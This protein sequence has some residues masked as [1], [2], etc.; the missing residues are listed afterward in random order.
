[1]ATSN[2]RLCG[3]CEAQHITKY[4]DQWCPECDE[5]LCSDCESHHKISKSSRNHGVISIENYQKLPSSISEIGN[6]C[7][8]HDMKYTHF[9]QHHDTPC[10]PDCISTHHKDCVGL[11]SIREIIK[12]SK[13]S[14]LIDNIQQNLTDIKNNLD[15]IMKNRQQNMSEIQQQRQMF[16]DQI[17]QMRVKINSHLDTIEQNILQELDD[18][19]D[20]IKSKINELLKQI[21]QNAKTV[22]GLQSNIIAVK[23]YASD[24]QTFLGSKVIE[25]EVKKEEEYLMALP[26]DGCLQQLN[27][28]Y[29]INT[30]IQEILSTITTFGS[31]SIETSPPSVVIKTMKAKQAQIMSVMQHPSVQSIN[32]IKLT[33]HTTFN[34][35][36]GKCNNTI[37]GSIVCPNGKMI[38]VDFS[39]NSRLI[40][41]NANG[42]LRKKIRCSLGCPFDVACLD[43]TTVAVSTYSGIEIININSTKTERCI[44]TSKPCGGITHHNGVLIWCEQQR[45]IQ[46]MK[47]SDDII[48]TLVKQDNVPYYS[49]ITT[50]GDKIYQTNYNT[51]TVT[52]YTMKGGKLWEY[53]DTSV[54]NG[55][56]G[57]TLDNKYNIYVTSFASNIVVVLE[58]NGRQGRQL[59]SRDDG[60]KNSTG[61]YVNKSKNSVLVTNH[62]GPAFLYHMC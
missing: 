17:K 55:P 5:G 40:I 39:I 60:L 22:E 50:C 21:S 42:T 19:E 36:K 32:D 49:Y 4:A 59:I 11:L 7:Q 27:L 28:R 6:H 31:V 24:L 35:P 38:F 12:T 26:E 20:K 2:H 25:K 30:K 56:Q 61:I 16:Q 34:I 52:C 44:T 47:L 37:T 62:H 48:I 29:N 51:S 18:T 33:L 10:C 3:I 43:D 14:T 53:K 15:K 45:G 9:C 1:M 8:Y 41:L 58:P 54:L 46:M 57:I 23:E 13:T